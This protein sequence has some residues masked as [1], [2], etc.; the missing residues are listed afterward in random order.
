VSKPRA[1]TLLEL[2]V[3]LATVALIAAMLFPVLGAARSA[4]KKAACLSHFRVVAQATTLYLNDYDDSFMP[5]NYQ[6]GQTPNSRLDRTWVQMLLPYT[7]SFRVFECPADDANRPRSE[8]MFDQDLV[9][10]D[11]YSQYY[12]ASMHS[13]VGYNF[14]YL[15]PIYEF[16]NQW[17]SQPKQLSEIDVPDSMLVFLDSAWSVANGVPTGGGNWLVSPPCRYETV[18]GVQVDTI[19][20]AITLPGTSTGSS[21]AEIY[22][23][24]VGWEPEQDSENVYGGVWPWHQN[25]SNVCTVDGAARGLTIAQLGSGCDVQPQWQGNIFNPAIYA[26]FPR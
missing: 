6:P 20:A 25:R 11:L 19:A 26:W 17:I 23:P 14:Q 18:A 4:A 13:N 16:N 7:P 15:A 21:S 22:A 2:L 9:P 1:F 5:V 3:V 12:T 8:A 24:V 10:G